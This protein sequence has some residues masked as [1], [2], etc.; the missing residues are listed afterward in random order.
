MARLY[1]VEVVGALLGAVRACL[2]VVVSAVDGGAGIDTSHNAIAAAEAH[3]TG[4]ATRCGRAHCGARAEERRVERRLHV[5]LFQA[6]IT[7]HDF[8]PVRR[9]A[10]CVC[11]CVCVCVYVCVGG[12]EALKRVARRSLML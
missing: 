5:A 9:G 2:L 11:V 3:L 12:R 7:T 10:V 4:A 8:E 6:D 1:D